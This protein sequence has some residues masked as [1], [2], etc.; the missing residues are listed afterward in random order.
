MYVFFK[1]GSVAQLVLERCYLYFR[2]LGTKECEREIEMGENEKAKRFNQTN[3]KLSPTT[4]RHK[5]FEC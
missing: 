5:S 1:R 2:R 3:M 4:L